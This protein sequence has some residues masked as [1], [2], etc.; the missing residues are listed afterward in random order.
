M[1]LPARI[2]LGTPLFVTVRSH[3]V[4]TVVV[5]VVLLL[6]DVGSIVVEE[7]DELAV[8]VCAAMFGATFTTTVMSTAEPALM[9]GF[10]QVTEAVTVHN[11]PAG[12]ATETNVVLAG[13]ASV[14]MTAEAGPG[15]LFVTVCVYVILFPA[16]TVGVAAVLSA[17]SA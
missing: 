7:T 16:N 2:G 1:L 5:T 15:P 14:N 13:I 17:R 8:I 3:A 11:Q 4:M 12:G 9:L 6:A 10:E